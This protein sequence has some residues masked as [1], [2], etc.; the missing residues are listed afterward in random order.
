VVVVIS[1]IDHG[2]KDL[3]FLFSN[4]SPVKSADELFGFTGKHA[5]TDH[6]NPSG[7]ILRSFSAKVWFRKHGAI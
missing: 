6:F 3:D 5:A 7:A 2:F 1:F 4:K